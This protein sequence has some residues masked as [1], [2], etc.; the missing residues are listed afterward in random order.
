MVI[1]ISPNTEDIRNYIKMRLDRDTDPEAMSD[2]LRVDVM[3]IILDKISDMYVGALPALL[4]MVYAYQRLC[5]DS[6]SFRSTW[7]LFL[8]RRQFVREDGNCKR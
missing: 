3:K 4:P 6:F 5:S 2:Y 7:M 8:E 1:P